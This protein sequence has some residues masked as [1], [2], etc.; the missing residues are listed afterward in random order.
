[1]HLHYLLVIHTYVSITPNLVLKL[2]GST[3]DA[4]LKYNEG[5]NLSFIDPD[6]NFLIP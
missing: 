5:Y 6:Y 4:S 3:I 2:F 1:M